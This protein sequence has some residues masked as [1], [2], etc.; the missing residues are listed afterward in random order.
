MIHLLLLADS[1]TDTHLLLTDMQNCYILPPVR[2]VVTLGAS[3]LASGES[4]SLTDSW[5]SSVD[6]H[7][8]QQ[9]CAEA[10]R[11]ETG[12]W[13]VVE[14]PAGE[15][16]LAA[17]RLLWL[18]NLQ[19]DNSM[20]RRHS[21]NSFSS[22]GGRKSKTQKKKVWLNSACGKYNTIKILPGSHV[23][24]HNLFAKQFTDI[25]IHGPKRMSQF[26][27]IKKFWD[28]IKGI[29]TMTIWKIRKRIRYGL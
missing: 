2:K 22:S 26:V 6:V 27:V 24:P 18:V 12:C 11:P 9:P 19:D 16:L 7:P 23:S 20:R 28:R 21:N 13:E 5:V 10:Y 15:G 3:S 4:V 14:G 8:C 29:M 17:E 25:D 1:S